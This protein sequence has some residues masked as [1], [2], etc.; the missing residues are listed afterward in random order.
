GDGDGGVDAPA[1][2]PIGVDDQ[3][4]ELDDDCDGTVDNAFD[5]QNDSNNCGMCNRRCIG[6]GAVQRCSAGQC[7][8]VMCQPGFADLDGDPLTCEYMC[9]LFPAR[10][11]DCNGFD[12]DCDGVIDE[13]LPPPPTGQCRVTAN[14]PC[15]GTTMVC[16]TRGGQTRW[17]CDYDAAVEFDPSVPNGIVLAEQKCDGEDGDCDG[18]VDDTFADLGQECDNG[19]LGVCR[20]V[21]E[22]ICDPANPAQT[23]CDLTVLPDAS[24]PSVELCDGLD[25]NCDGTVDNATG[26]D[27]VID[28]MTHV[29]VG[30]LDY[31]VD[32]YEASRPDAT[33][34]SGGVSAARSCSKP[35]VLP[36]RNVSYNVAQAACA[37]AGKTLCSATQWQTACEGA[38][39]TTY[40][41]GDTF[42]AAACNTE[43]HDGIPGGDDDDVRLA[44]GAL[45]ACVASTGAVDLS[46]NLKEWTDDITGQT[47][48]GV[49]IAVLRGGAYDTPAFGAT[50]DF[51]T[52][53]A[54]VNVLEQTYGFRCCRATAP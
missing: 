1:C 44:T 43:P 13:D 38:T 42:S 5:K 33:P 46:G 2:T 49:D 25:N 23:T 45:A 3:C 26:P 17:F 8:F 32:T 31:Y 22:R 39:N 7:E 36:W 27:R 28:D 16:A 29:Q 52:S 37:A 30:M 40:P 21:G 15:A 24:P 10:A 6:A 9:P 34:L 12:D 48:G 20:D 4:N 19:G 54:A 50:C 41:Y 18:V 14:T 53:R 51:R 47:A 11:E 35:G